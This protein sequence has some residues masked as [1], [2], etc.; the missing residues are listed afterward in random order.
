METI[1]YLVAVLFSATVLL[2]CFLVRRYYPLRNSKEVYRVAFEMKDQTV[3][4]STKDVH[5][6]LI[7]ISDG[8]E[9]MFT[10]DDYD[11]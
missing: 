3:A 7:A 8:E 2:V 10:I 4:P 9:E 5:P 1:V 6:Q 11:D